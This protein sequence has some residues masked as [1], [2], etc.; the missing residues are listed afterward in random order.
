MSHLSK[1]LQ[2]QNNE[3]ILILIASGVVL[4]LILLALGL[5]LLANASFLLNST[6]GKNDNNDIKTEE[7]V[8]TLDIDEVPIATNSASLFISGNVNNFDKVEVYINKV[9][10]K[11]IATSVED[12]FNEKIS[13]LKQGQNEIYIKATNTKAKQ[14]RKSEV[15]PVEYKKKLELELKE[16][17]EGATIRTEDVKV[18]GTTDKD[19]TVQVNNHPAVVDSSGTFEATI[20]LKEGENT[21][22]IEAEDL[23]GNTQKKEIKVMYQ[24][25]E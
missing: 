22:V 5:K 6:F 17:Q 9:L 13:G 18:I 14:E 3:K 24:K 16:P 2:K 15:F 7:F 12:S 8:G 19:T 20:R 11:T 25:D 4:G 21:L 1:H 23:A 10:R